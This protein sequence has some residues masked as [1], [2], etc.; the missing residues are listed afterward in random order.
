VEPPEPEDPLARV[1]PIAAAALALALSGPVEAQQPAHAPAAAEVKPPEPPPV[2]APADI[3]AAAERV[4]SALRKTQAIAR[5]DRDAQQ[6]AERLP[7]LTAD[8]KGRARAAERRLEEYVSLDTLL[9]LAS[10]WEGRSRRLARDRETLTARAKA[11]DA[12]LGRLAELRAL[13]ERSRDGAR[14]SAAPPAVLDRAAAILDAIGR[15]RDAVQRR[16]AVVLT[17]QSGVAGLEAV[18]ADVLDAVAAARSEE[19]Q[20][21]FVRDAPP[22]WEALGARAPKGTLGERLRASWRD[23]VLAVGDFAQDRGLAFAL[24]LALFALTWLTASAFRSR[25]EAWAQQDPSVAASAQCLRRPASAALVVALLAMPWI[26]EDAPSIVREVSVLIVVV[27]V[28]RLLPE[29][30]PARTRSAVFGLMGLVVLDRLRDMLDALP[31]VERELLALESLGG[32]V[33]VAWVLRR[34]EVSR[35]PGWALVRAVALRLAAL[36]FAASIAGNLVGNLNLARL[37]ASATVAAL[38]IAVILYTAARIFDGLVS[39][40]LRTRTAQR[41]RMVRNHG[42]LLRRRGFAAVHAAMVVWWAWLTLRQFSL[43]EAF[44]AGV[45][46]VVGASVSF[47]AVE[48]ALGDV[49]LFGVTIWGTFLFSRFVR[50]ALEEDVM[51]RLSLPRGVPYAVSYILHYGILLL[52]FLLAV[53][54]AGFELGNVTLLAGALGVGIGF[55]LQNVVNNFISGLILLFER[56]VQVGDTIQVGEVLGEVRRIG[57]RSSTV[58]TWQGAEVIVPNGTLISEQVVN[59]TLS[60]RE[61]RIDVQVGVAY[62]TDPERVLALLLEVAAKHG[63]VLAHPAPAALFLGFGDSSLNF[64]LRAWTQNSADWMRIR[65]DLNVAI[66]AALAAAAIEIP[67]PQR[68]LHLRSVSA[69]LAPLVSGGRPAARGAPQPGPDGSR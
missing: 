14:E 33:F 53:A 64:E 4:E 40:G 66:H 30:L 62:G 68:D 3:A 43:E 25:A 24:H 63:E 69:G 13:W 37:L 11:L 1:A 9:D 54:A 46:A 56:P 35:P 34:V 51:P 61:R 38:L 42:P 10:E 17:L 55:G 57:I 41:L 49:L 36:F 8:L 12:E 5:P 29:D 52:G 19:R 60:D 59:W 23:Q 18:V 50:F 6:I 31:V 15:T 26:Y 45:G 7:A 2:I 67:F 44:V 27:P 32:L 22:F 47:G 48:I 28:L 20:R 21:L 65:S 39:V 58:R 16:R